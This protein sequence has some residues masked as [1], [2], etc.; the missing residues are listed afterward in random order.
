[1]LSGPLRKFMLL[2]SSAN[3][4][5]LT[6]TTKKWCYRKKKLSFF[7]SYQ[8]HTFHMF[9]PKKYWKHV[10]LIACYLTNPR[11]SLFHVDSPNK[12][13]FPQEFIFYLVAAI[14]A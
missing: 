6:L 1:M 10:A 9:A 7:G 14:L 5:F 8:I 2:E 13:H 3:H 4:H 11:H 12:V